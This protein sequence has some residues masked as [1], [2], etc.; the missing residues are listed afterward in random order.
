MAAWRVIY[1]AGVK[2]MPVQIGHACQKIAELENEEKTLGNTLAQTTAEM[3]KAQEHY[4]GSANEQLKAEEAYQKIRDDYQDFVQNNMQEIQASGTLK[5][6]YQKIRI[7]KEN[8]VSR[9][10]R[11]QSVLERLQGELK[12][13]S[14]ALESAESEAEGVREDLNMYQQES[15]HLEKS[16]GALK[17]RLETGEGD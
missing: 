4:R 14:E 13:R 15:A 5:E 10:D 2:G 7:E 6:A 3:A 12:E 8:L 9:R 16:V 1:E 11:N 17:E